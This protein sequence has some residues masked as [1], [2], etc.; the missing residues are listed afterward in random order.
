MPKTH[1]LRM[2]IDIAAPTTV[3]WNVVSDH[4]GVPNWGPPLSVRIVEDGKPERNG[5]GAVRAVQFPRAPLVHERITL[6]EPERTY[7][8]KIFKGFPGLVD[9]LGKLT[10]EDA[11][12]GKTRL[13]WDIDF[14][15]KPWHPFA[16]IASWWMRKLETQ[17][18]TGMEKLKGQLEARASA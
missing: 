15:F 13:R 14:Q 18:M 17:M 9:H 11:G 16:W 1:V 10:V 6:F 8:Y 7:E 2:T 5:L 4:E 3:V 12:S